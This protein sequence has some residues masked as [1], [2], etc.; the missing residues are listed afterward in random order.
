MVIRCPGFWGG[1]LGEWLCQLLKRE[2]LEEQWVGEKLIGSVLDRL[3]LY[4]VMSSKQVVGYSY[5][6]G[7]MILGLVM[8]F[9]ESSVYSSGMGP[10]DMR[11]TLTLQL[12]V[13]GRDR[14]V[15]HSNVMWL[16]A[17]Q[18]GAQRRGYTANIIW[19]WHIGG[20][21]KL[22]VFSVE[23]WSG[24]QTKEGQGVQ[25]RYTFQKTDSEGKKGS[26]QGEGPRLGKEFVGKT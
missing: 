9:R 14:Y 8:Y 20:K 19:S 13:D 7:I 21:G 22:S 3:S 26:C 5:I 4:L 18:G 2:T 12:T 11:M 25:F 6:S 17:G 24:C 16:N 10:G 15:N 23:R 1:Q